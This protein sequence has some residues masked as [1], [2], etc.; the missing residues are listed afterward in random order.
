MGIALQ[1]EYFFSQD[2]PVGELHSPNCNTTASQYS[3]QISSGFDG[4]K[5]SF[6]VYINALNNL[7]GI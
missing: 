4:K 1:L 5:K 2:L 6:S 7:Q 3:Y